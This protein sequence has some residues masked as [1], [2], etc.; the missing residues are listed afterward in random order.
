[1]GWPAKLDNVVAEADKQAQEDRDNFMEELRQERDR[2]A[3]ELEA[4]ELEVKA[5][6][7]L[8]ELAETEVCDKCLPSLAG[9]LAR[10]CVARARAVAA[11]IAADVPR[12]SGGE[13]A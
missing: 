13:L 4:W 6:S 11:S 9:R 12:D 1:M 3:E 2:F 5:L 7:T 10:R 8:G